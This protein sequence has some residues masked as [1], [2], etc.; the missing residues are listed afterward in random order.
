MTVTRILGIDP[1]SRKAGVGII[2]IKGN[3]V[4]HV[5]HH[6]IRCGTG[7]F[8]ERLGILFSELSEIIKVYKPSCASVEDVFVSKNVSSALKLGQARG[9]LIAACCHANLEV[10]TYTP[11]AIKLATVG[12][13]RAD[14]A[15]VQH[16]IKVLLKPPLPLP[17]DAADALAA[18]LCHA[19]HVPLKNR[20]KNVT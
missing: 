13:G 14:K 15:Q 16:M 2:D 6:V 7:P 10:S 20:L 18:C 17:E 5:H 3:R 19:H 12:H 1:G 11:T 8:T 9:A 4:R